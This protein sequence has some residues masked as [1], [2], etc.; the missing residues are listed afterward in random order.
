MGTSSFIDA[1]EPKKEDPTETQNITDIYISVFFDGTG[2]NIYE[3]INKSQSLFNK[4]KRRG[5]QLISKVTY[6]SSPTLFSANDLYHD[7]HKTPSSHSNKQ[8]LEKYG[9]KDYN[10]QKEQAEYDYTINDTNNKKKCRQSRGFQRQWRLEIFKCGN[11]PFTYKN[12]E[13]G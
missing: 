10:L 4:L 9:M 11:S 5:K 2:N 3:Q 8:D 13:K 7:M 12:A 6:S 1:K